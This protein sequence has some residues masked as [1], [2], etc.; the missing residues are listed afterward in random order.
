MKN[1]ESHFNNLFL[2]DIHHERSAS[3]PHGSKYKVSGKPGKIEE[4]KGKSRFGSI[5]RKDTVKS[6]KSKEP[7]H[8]F[9]ADE[10]DMSRDEIAEIMIKLKNNEISQ[11][12]AMAVVKKYVSYTF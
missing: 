5:F 6:N 12:E 10:L 8:E 7:H 1:Y 4:G 3:A 9:K 11:E 2:A